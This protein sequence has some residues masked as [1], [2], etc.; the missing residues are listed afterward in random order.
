MAIFI[1][2]FGAA[3]CVLASHLRFCLWEVR[4]EELRGLGRFGDVGSGFGFRFRFIGCRVSG[5]TV[6]FRDRL[7]DRAARQKT[8]QALNCAEGGQDRFAFEYWRLASIE[9]PETPI[10]I[11]L[12]VHVSKQYIRWP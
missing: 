2:C 3:L 5:S 1:F 12:R 11:R 10:S 4:V 8:L 6:L 9:N 7:W